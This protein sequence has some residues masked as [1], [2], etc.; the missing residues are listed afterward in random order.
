MFTII[1]CSKM[2]FTLK[3][4]L[5]ER[6]SLKSLSTKLDQITV[7]CTKCVILCK[8]G[9]CCG[10]RAHSEPDQRTNALQR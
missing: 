3:D 1:L 10:G 4:D 7:H 8:C 9:G 6:F 5:R 2:L